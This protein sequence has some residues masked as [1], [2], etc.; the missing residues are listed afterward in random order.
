MKSSR[1]TISDDS[2]AFSGIPVEQ[3][4]KPNA[5]NANR[6][7]APHAGP[8]L[9]DLDGSVAKARGHRGVLARCCLK[10]TRLIVSNQP[11]IFKSTM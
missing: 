9:T 5:A 2:S 6:P 4:I 8:G 11:P 1:H 7:T 10:H 3:R